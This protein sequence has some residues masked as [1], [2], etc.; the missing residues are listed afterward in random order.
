M[1]N[2]RI[3]FTIAATVTLA[4]SCR[5]GTDGESFQKEIIKSY[6][7]AVDAFAQAMPGIGGDEKS[8]WAA[9]TV[10]QIARNIQKNNYSYN[11]SMARIYQMQNLTAY[12]MSYFS[13]VMGMPKAI[14]GSS[15]VLH[16]TETSDSLYA[17]VEKAKF[18]DGSKLQELAFMSL[19]HMQMFLHLQNAIQEAEKERTVY[20]ESS[21]GASFYCLKILET[22]RKQ[23]IYSEQDLAR[24][25]AQL[26]GT[27]FFNTLCP[28]VL[29]FSPSEQAFNANKSKL[30][31]A[32]NFF[33]ENANPIY[34]AVQ[35]SNSIIPPLSDSEYRDFLRK[36]TQYKVM[37]LK[38]AAEEMK[39]IANDRKMD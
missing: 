32:A 26:E 6:T 10:H 12:G 34:N 7:E 17:L 24:I 21:Y 15:E 29:A 23:G 16:M 5:Q 35:V 14:E 25:S 4:S 39:S 22:L 37:L 1:M 19:Y 27:V 31:E 33:D 38:I 36:A 9:D 11:E 30:M 13:G 18:Q 3:I 20:T 28:L 2:R 8:I